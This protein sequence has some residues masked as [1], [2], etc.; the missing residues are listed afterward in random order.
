MSKKFRL[1][2]VLVLVTGLFGGLLTGST[3]SADPV[4]GFIVEIPR[5]DIG[6]A[7]AAEG[8]W[9]TQ[10]QIQN[11]GGF[12]GGVVVFFWDAY[13]GECPSNAP[14][15]SGHACMQ[16]PPGGVWTL[17]N[18]I[19]DSAKSAI[20]Y[21]IGGGPIDFQNACNEAGGAEGSTEDWL[22]WTD[23]WAWLGGP[24]LAVTV[25]RW[26][27]DPFGE[28]EI[29][30]S[31]TGIAD[32]TTMWDDEVFAPYVMHGYHDLDTVITIQ[33]SGEMCTS[34]WIYY[35]EEGNCESMKA[36]HIELLAPGESIT[37]GP[38]GFADMAF[39]TPE[40]DAPWLG[41][42]YITSNEP[43]AV[44]V[45]QL[46]LTGDNRAV[47]ST[48]RGMPF[49]YDWNYTWYADLL[50]REIS[51]WDSSIQVQNLTK[52]SMPTFVTVEFFDQSGDSILFVGD[53]VCRNGAKT[54][55]L[56]AITDLG[57]NYPFGYVGAAEIMSHWQ[58]DYPGGGHGGEPIFAVVDLKK[59]KV[60][61]DTTGFW[62]HTVA[63]E[64]QAGSYNAHPY[65]QKVNAFGWAMPYIAKEQLGVTS[66]IAIRNNANCNKITGWIE[67]YDETGRMVTTIP[68]PWLQPKHMKIVDLAYFGQLPRGFV[69]AAT[70]WV[71]N[72]E[73]LCD[74]NA[75]GITDQEPIMPS[76]VVLNYGFATELPIGSGAGPLT[77]LGDLTRVYEAIPYGYGGLDCEGS[78]FGTA[79][80]RQALNGFDF[81][82]VEDVDVWVN[83]EDTGVDTDSTGGYQV[84][85][86]DEGFPVVTFKKS[87]FFDLDMDAEVECGKETKL[88]PELICS[89]P[90]FV[91]VEDMSDNPIPG[92]TVTVV[93]TF[94]VNNDAFETY[95]T[96]D[97]TDNAGQ[98]NTMDVA[99]AASLAVTASA[100]GHDDGTA[101][102][103][104]A[105]N[106]DCYA[107]PTVGVELCKYNTVVGTVTI[108]TQPAAGYTLK[109]I[110]MSDPLLPEV[111]SD[112][113]TA[114]GV[115]ALENLS[116]G[117][118]PLYRIQLWSP[119]DIYIGFT[120]I[121]TAGQCGATGLLTYT[122]GFG[123]VDWTP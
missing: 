122:N 61:D 108:G 66:R 23:D 123:T 69:G 85:P 86:V 30:S 101:T 1:L 93:A 96:S 52:D 99:G 109:A 41:S 22:I 40:I 89:N 48:M 95:E 53:W 25:D 79:T 15:P 117:D 112:V 49:W 16:L 5:I 27:T 107:E 115:Y 78:L 59:S 44:I 63:G 46:S 104:L 8:D 90:L 10:I 35:K 19:P 42:A 37:V 80:V 36:Q 98:V 26:G 92:A 121:T 106:N 39:P 9:D 51:G 57:V 91:T 24:D 38:A 7:F 114:A 67:I 54:F 60:Y 2:M 17:H 62:R 100:L 116:Q 33:N 75:D 64:T 13:S 58:V 88:D 120:D 31:Y 70:F 111:D 32:Y 94:E 68:V 87:G 28:F 29:S 12:Y 71:S 118:G 65:W 3:V 110:N 6:D 21:S 81:D 11:V 18:Q 72:V 113:T 56:P 50:Y 76:A 97:V 83:G 119:S 84:R 34:I 43:L 20:V 14:G 47:L 105:D 4:P 102:V 45:D 103:A 55:Y 73:Q 74:T 82:Y 77:D